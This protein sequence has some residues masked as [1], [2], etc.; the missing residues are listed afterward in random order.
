M[1][2]VGCFRIPANH[3]CL[4][5]H[6][7]RSPLVPGVLLLDAALTLIIAGL[8]GMTLAGFT[9]V[10][11]FAAVPPEQEVTVRCALPAEGRVSFACLCA[12]A[13]CVQGT[14]IVGQRA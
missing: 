3:P 12:G 7:P 6:F 8:P 5:G 4:P 1:H 10:K 13:T 11:F 14:A 2:S 9:A